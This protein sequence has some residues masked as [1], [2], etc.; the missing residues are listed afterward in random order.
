MQYSN[1]LRPHFRFF[2][3]LFKAKQERKKERSNWD[4]SLR[5]EKVM[6]LLTSDYDTNKRDR[7][8]N[9]TNLRSKGEVQWCGR[10]KR[11]KFL[12]H[13]DD[14]VWTSMWLKIF[15][16]E[17]WIP[18]QL[19]DLLF[20]NERRRKRERSI[21][22]FVRGQKQELWSLVMSDWYL[23]SGREREVQLFTHSHCFFLVAVLL[24]SR[25][26]CCSSSSSSSILAPCQTERFLDQ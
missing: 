16:G 18:I 9:T 14:D 6:L 15:K 3:L 21:I 22:V 4:S 26:F 19:C 7:C 25:C 1:N 20:D 24:P 2:F 11:V 10:E 8:K 13:N 12:T 17:K 5:S 23:P